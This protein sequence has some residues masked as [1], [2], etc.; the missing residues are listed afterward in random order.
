G[1]PRPGGGR[2]VGGGG[3][4][5]LGPGGGGGG[6]GGGFRLYKFR[7]MT[8]ARDGE[9]RLLGDE[10]RLTGL[11]R[12]VRRWSVD[13]LPQL[14]NVLRGEMSLVGPRPLLVEYLGRYSA[15]QARRHEVKPGVT[16]WAQVHGRNAVSWG[17]KLEMDVWY[18]ENRSFWLDVRILAMT[19]GKVLRREGI[20]QAGRATVEEF[21][22][23]GPPSLRYGGQGGDGA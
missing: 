2:G 17:E 15:R 19:V 13:E 4:G 12:W 1:P 14:W 16:G 10:E 5:G 9:G 21:R 20:S 23:E 8:E 22:G 6:G 3:G 18:V 7:T 11:G